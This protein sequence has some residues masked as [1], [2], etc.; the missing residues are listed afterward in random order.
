[1]E[2]LNDREG[3]QANTAIQNKE[4]LRFES[5]PLNE[6]DQFYELL[7]AGCMHRIVTDIAVKKAL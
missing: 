1:M 4:I 7:M 2:V 5:F 3:N 6:E